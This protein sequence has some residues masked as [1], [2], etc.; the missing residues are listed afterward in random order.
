MAAQR[1][2][3]KKMARIEELESEVEQLRR[4]KEQ[5]LAELV[6]LGARPPQ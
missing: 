4:E 5:M 1:C 3:E 2:R 6:R